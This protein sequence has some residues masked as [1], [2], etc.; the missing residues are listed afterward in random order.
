MATSTAISSSPNMKKIGWLKGSKTL[1]ETTVVAIHRAMVT[2]LE[3]YFPGEKVQIVRMDSFSSNKG[4]A[5]MSWFLEAMIH[6]QF[7]PPGQHAYLGDLE[8]WWYPLLVRCLIAL[9]QGSAPR[10]QWFNAMR[11][12]LDKEC[13]LANSLDQEDPTCAYERALGSKHNVS[14]LACFYSPARFVLDKGGLPNKFAERARAGFW[15]G[16]D[17]SFVM[18]GTVGSAIF[19]DG[20]I[21][22]TVLNNFLHPAGKV[23]GAHRA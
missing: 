14:D 12:A 22:R 4:K 2:E 16:R 3:A 18:N 5:M 20:N 1:D 8:R 11:D 6:A 13:A 15:V 7:T 19:W 17:I 10:A 23:S 9:R 21:H